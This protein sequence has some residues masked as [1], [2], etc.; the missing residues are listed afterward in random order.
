MDRH[1]DQVPAP[2]RFLYCRQPQLVSGKVEEPLAAEVSRRAELA[3]VD[4]GGLRYRIDGAKRTVNAVMCL[5]LFFLAARYISA[6]SWKFNPSGFSHMM[7]LPPLA[8]AMAMSLWVSFGVA[9]ITAST[10]G[11]AAISL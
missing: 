2:G 10:P 3:A 1:V 4:R 5:T 8:Q 11:S 6:D 9:M 7:C